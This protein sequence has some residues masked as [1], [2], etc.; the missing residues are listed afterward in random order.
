MRRIIWDVLCVSVLLTIIDVIIY[1]IF[2]PDPGRILAYHTLGGP[3]IHNLVIE[4]LT[5]SFTINVSLV[6]ISCIFIWALLKLFRLIFRKWR[7]R[8][9]IL[10]DYLP[11]SIAGA[12]IIFL[13]GITY[14]FEYTRKPEIIIPVSF[15]AFVICSGL[16]ILFVFIQKRSENIRTGKVY[17]VAAG[18]VVGALI[19]L[20]IWQVWIPV[21]K[22]AWPAAKPPIGRPNVVIVILD[23]LRR[24]HISIYEQGTPPQTPNINK[25]GRSGVTYKYAFSTSTWTLPSM[26]AMH[27]SRYPSST[28][29]PNRIPDEIPTIAEEMKGLGYD[30]RGIIGNPILY[31]EY[32]FD[33]GYNNYSRMHELDPLYNFR[34][35]TGYLFLL[36]VRNFIESKI[37]DCKVQHT[38]IQEFGTTWCNERSIKYLRNRSDNDR[39]F[40]LY[41]H[42]FDPHGPLWAPP[43]YIENKEFTY[44][45]NIELKDKDY[46]RELYA[47]ECRYVD[48]AVGKLWAVL[49][50]TGQLE[51]TIFIVT[52]D[53]GEEL[54]ERGAY[55][56]GHTMY[57]ELTH[58]PLLIY[59]P[60]GIE[61][62]YSDEPVSL[63]D[64]MPTILD[65]AG[66]D[67]QPTAE[68][69][70][71]IQ[72]P[73]T[74]EYQ[75]R[76]IVMEYTLTCNDNDLAL[77]KDNLYFI[78]RGNEKTGEIYDISAFHRGDLTPPD[79]I[80]TMPIVEIDLKDELDIHKEHIYKERR[81]YKKDDTLKWQKHHH[82]RLKALGYI[83]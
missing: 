52:S 39:P 49:E 27:T 22:S 54:M 18:I 33:K 13:F 9:T 30:T 53:H 47:S 50:E 37:F 75:A 73:N 24:D 56:H 82:E 2:N 31:T 7:Y 42:Y 60:P 32:G 58:I 48:D 19:L 6:L 78:H 68:G 70:S 21:I 45:G 4:I 64:I 76:P 74:N 29:F 40:F 41:V 61:G 65:A 34:Y 46:I 81:H 83:K 25:V 66:D 1:P 3:N 80:A 72:K 38:S 59:Y 26:V 17:K 5:R 35:S 15:G 10:N 14:L 51:N 44:P 67:F 55:E 79:L 63:L 57:P 69:I 71:L 20:N 23:A 36:R 8:D 12:F 28:G 11:V 43:E 77:F 62:Y 16:A